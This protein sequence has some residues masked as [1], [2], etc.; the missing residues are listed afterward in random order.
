MTI[1]LLPWR[2]AFYQQQ[3][4]RLTVE[5]SLV[6]LLLVFC[7]VV[8]CIKNQH[9]LSSQQQQ[10]AALESAIQATTAEYMTAVKQQKKQVDA[11][12]KE[13]FLKNKLEQNQ[14]LFAMLDM[15]VMQ[16]PDTIYLLQIYRKSSVLHLKGKASSP[17]EFSKFLEN[18][19]TT[20]KKPPILAQLAKIAGA[21]NAVEFDVAYEIST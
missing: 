10:I 2:E 1:N 7:W 13:G 15:I 17:A 8:L 9:I 11:A 4:R 3:K 18:L 14:N 6:G 20:L 19:K 16:M 21:V 5:L 12:S